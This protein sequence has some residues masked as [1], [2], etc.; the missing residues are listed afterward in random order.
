MTAKKN[1]W[2]HSINYLVVIAVISIGILAG[3][4]FIGATIF[5]TYERAE[6]QSI[7]HLRELLDTVESTVSLSLIHI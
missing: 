2:R 4:I 7:T 5:A 1:S 3:M 6:K